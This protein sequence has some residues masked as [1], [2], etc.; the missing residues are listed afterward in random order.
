MTDSMKKPWFSPM[1]CFLGSLA[2]L[3]M[4]T[5]VR[6]RALPFLRNETILS[7][8]QL[9]PTTEWVAFAAKF[10]YAGSAVALVVGIVAL[11]SLSD[12]NRRYIS[13]LPK[14]QRFFIWP[15]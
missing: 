7:G 5:L 2:A 15:W 6:H 10:F 11:V 9:V 3:V 14:W 12:A 1:G 13:Q 8:G 4:P